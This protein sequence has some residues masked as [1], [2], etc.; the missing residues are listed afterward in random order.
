MTLYI[1]MIAFYLQ[2]AGGVTVVWKELII[3]MLRDKWNLVL[4]LQNV[5]CE[6]IYFE[7][8]MSF[9]PK[10]IY[11]HGISVKVNR[12]KAVNC[13]MENDCKFV[14]TYYRVT[15][16]AN[17]KQFTIVHDFTYEY[18]AKGIRKAVHQYQKKKSIRKADNIICVSENTKKDLL[19][20]YPWAKDKE[21]HIIYNGVSNI[22]K[23][24]DDKEK[25]DIIG[26]DSRAPFFVYVGSRAEYKR[27][28]MA[29]D[30]AAHYGYNLIIVGGGQL[31]DDEKQRLDS[32]LKDNYLHRVGIDEN[33]LNLIYN[34]ALAL[35][36]PS[37][38]E[39]FGIPILEAQK[40]GCPVLARK[41]SSIDEV[42]MNNDVLME[43]STLS[44][45]KKIIELFF[46]NKRRK[47]IIELGYSNAL[48]FSWD[49]TY[50]QYRKLL[51]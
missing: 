35:L 39:G 14:S 44:E 17:V 27:F 20:F 16:Y 19:K 10:C 42:M 33:E 47:Q 30:I 34:K 15:N 43:K 37:E 41:G 28:D 49:I 38:Y 23:P 12:Y 40:A 51:G 9:N 45:A 21:I 25:I 4:I 29:I 3:R 36:Y 2:K 18:Y 6:N 31:N 5:N 24:I 1:D 8:I 13:P 11:E 48:R 50:E 22:Y 7:E 32:K 26:L 46:D